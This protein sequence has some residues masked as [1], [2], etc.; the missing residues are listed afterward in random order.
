MQVLVVV[1]NMRSELSIA[2]EA[3]FREGLAMTGAKAQSSFHCL[4]GTTKVM[5]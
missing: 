5:P 3:A 1:K 2:S 4:C